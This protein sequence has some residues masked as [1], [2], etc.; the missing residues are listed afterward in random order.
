MRSLNS[1]VEK[2]RII[3]DLTVFKEGT[4]VNVNDCGWKHCQLKFFLYYV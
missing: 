3:C 1:Q 2:M 4:S